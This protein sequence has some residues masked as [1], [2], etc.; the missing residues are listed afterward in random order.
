MLASVL[1]T[2]VPLIVGALL[3][4]AARLGLDLPEGAVTELVTVLVTAAYYALGRLVEEH[5]D[6]RVGRVLLS[7]G[8]A[9]GRP[10]YYTPG[11]V[12]R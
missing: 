12:S 6:P 8:L 3:A 1:R 10:V 2:V 11:E 4:Q 7:L 5:V 9:R